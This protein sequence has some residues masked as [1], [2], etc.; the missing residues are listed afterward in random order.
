M[1]IESEYLHWE[2]MENQNTT[3]DTVAL[4]NIEA[5]LRNFNINK[6][7]ISRRLNIISKKTSVTVEYDKLPPVFCVEVGNTD[8][9]PDVMIRNKNFSGFIDRPEFR[10]VGLIPL[11][12][13]ASDEL[14]LF[15]L[16]ALCKN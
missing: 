12:F 13:K 6:E 8:V 16:N 4:K 15:C 14:F 5:C 11:H 3:L 7:L 2:D 1:K 9:H 10:Q